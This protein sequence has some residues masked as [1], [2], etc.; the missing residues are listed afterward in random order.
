MPAAKVGFRQTEMP[1]S[2]SAREFPDH[3][4]RRADEGY[5]RQGDDEFRLEPVL[6]LPLVQHDLEGADPDGKQGKA[7]EIHAGGGAPDVGGIRE[8]EEQH[9]Q[10]DDPDGEIDVEHP[11]PG[12]GIGDPAPQRRPENR[13]GQDARGP[14]GHRLPRS[15]TEN[16]SSMIAW[17]S[18]CSPPPVMACI[19]RKKIRNGRLGAR[20]QRN[21]AVKPTT[22]AIRSRFRPK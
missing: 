10:A 4:G 14:E 9:H 13:R 15:S 12:V 21:D 19:T 5:D 22:A 16:S 2:G 6:L 8:E 3:E 1:P 18:G 17:E 7:P 20:P 11:A